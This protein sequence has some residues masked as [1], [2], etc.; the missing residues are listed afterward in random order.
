[1]SSKTGS[2]A[3]LYCTGIGKILL[4]GMK[5]SELQKY[6]KKVD[7]I[8]YTSNTLNS[9]QELLNEI[10]IIRRDGYAEDREEHEDRNNFV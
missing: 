5:E 6:L 10:D 8:K 7:F 4:A 2:H 9:I 1:M 3:P